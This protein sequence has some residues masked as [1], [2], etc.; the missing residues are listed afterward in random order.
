MTYDQLLEWIRHELVLDSNPVL[1]YMEWNTLRYRWNVDDYMKQIDHLMEYFPIQR[2]TMIA[3]LAKPISSEFVAELRNM[4]IRLEGMSVPKLKE[5][6]KNHLIAARGH[7][8]TRSSYPERHYTRYEHD[9]RTSHQ[10]TPAR[11]D[12]C[13][14]ATP[15]G[16]PQPVPITAVAH[17]D[18]FGEVSTSRSTNKNPATST[19]PFP[20]PP[21]DPSHHYIA[22]KYG[23]GPTPC[24]ICGKKGHGWVECSKRKKGKCGVCGSEAHWSWFCRQRYRP[25]PEARLNFQ[26][27]CLEAHANPDIELM[28]SP[29]DNED[30]ALDECLVQSPNESDESGDDENPRSSVPDASLCQVSISAP[31]K[32]LNCPLS[33]SEEMRSAVTMLGSGVMD[34]WKHFLKKICVDAT[35][36][37][38]PVAPP[39]LRGQLLYRISVEHVPVIALLDHGASHSFMC[40]EW[41]VR[42]GIPMRPLAH[43]FTFSFFNGTHDVISHLAYPKAVRIGPHIR[44][45][46]FFA[47]A[48]SP[49]PV[50]LGL[51]AIRG[52]PLFYSPLDNHL[53]IVD[54][55]G[56]QA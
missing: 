49:M 29:F 16:A 5:V 50:V 9:R 11:H 37:I 2:D 32:L 54:E 41:A 45:W 15:N 22:A 3:C 13:L 42:N 51:D 39:S 27:L 21:A 20:R 55:L 24:Y 23:E 12:L 28:N 48:S 10:S 8:T 56:R 47:V 30:N 38:F 46:T 18:P 52:W 7:H 4:D 34:R 53:F 25:A 26:T 19:K 17:K 6:I 33:P 31:P 35:S 1:A 40:K 14:H 43:P 44:P 36:S